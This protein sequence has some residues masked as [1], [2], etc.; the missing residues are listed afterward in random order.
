M[1][2]L[3]EVAEASSKSFASGDLSAGI[4]TLRTMLQ[5][6]AASELDKTTAEVLRLC[7]DG[8]QE[9]GEIQKESILLAL[10]TLDTAFKELEAS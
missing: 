7:I 10:F 5:W 6:M 2:E 9:G 3:E 8:L 1:V 4:T